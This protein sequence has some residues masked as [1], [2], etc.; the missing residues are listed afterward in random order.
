MKTVRRN[1]LTGNLNP[2]W[3][4]YKSW[5]K[6][7]KIDLKFSKSGDPNIEKTY[8]THFVKKGSVT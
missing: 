1:S 5:G 2:S 3:T 8:A 7:I 4:G 6:G